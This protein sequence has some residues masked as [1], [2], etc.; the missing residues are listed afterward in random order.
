MSNFD[1]LEISL[2]VSHNYFDGLTK[3]FSDLAKFFRF[4]QQNGSFRVNV[5]SCRLVNIGRFAIQ[6]RIVH[7]VRSFV[8]HRRT[9]F[10]VTHGPPFLS[11]PINRDARMNIA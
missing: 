9:H 6:S 10:C 7:C 3:V 11:F 1:V 8:S 4:L 5:A 2:S